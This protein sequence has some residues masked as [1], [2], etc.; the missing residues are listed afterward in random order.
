VGFSNSQQKFLYLP[1][2]HSDYI[3]SIICE[4]WGLLGAIV[5]LSGFFLILS[6]GLFIAI[7]VQDKFMKFMAVGLTLTIITQACINMAVSTGLMPSKGTTLPF[8]S[9]G[10]SSLLFAC[11]SMGILLSISKS[12]YGRAK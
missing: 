7:N 4:E 10:G 11:I 6:R 5:V 8:L 2:P 3:F 1:T 12:A 9:Y